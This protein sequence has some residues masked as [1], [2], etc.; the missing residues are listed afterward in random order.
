[1]NMNE[2]DQKERNTF[3]SSSFTVTDNSVT[4]RCVVVDDDDEEFIREGKSLSEMQPADIAGTLDEKDGCSN[5]GISK[6]SEICGSKEMVEPNVRPN[7]ETVCTSIPVEHLSI[8]TGVASA[9]PDDCQDSTSGWKKSLSSLGSRKK[10]QQLWRE[11]IDGFS[12]YQEWVAKNIRKRKKSYEDMPDVDIGLEEK[13][14]LPVDE[15][16][17]DEYDENTEEQYICRASLEMTHED[18]M[19]QVRRGVE[20]QGEE[21]AESDA[22]MQEIKKTWETEKLR[23]RRERELV[24][25]KE[26]VYEMMICYAC[27]RAF[28]DEIT[29]RNHINEQH[30]AQKNY[31]HKCRHCYRRFKLIH[32]LR[33]HEKLHDGTH[34]IKCDRCSAT[35]RTVKTLAIHKGRVHRINE[36]GKPISLDDCYECLKCHRYY[37]TVV[38]LNRHK[39]WCLNADTIK[40]KRRKTKL[41]QN[42]SSP[43]LSTRD[44]ESSP[45]GSECSSSSSRPKWDPVCPVCQ[46][47]FFNYPSMLRH[48]GRFHKGDVKLARVYKQT[49]SPNLPFA[50]RECFKRFASKASLSSHMKRHGSE[51]P[52]KCDQC[53]KSYIMGSEL[54]KH[55]RRVH[56]E[57]Q[58]NEII[59]SLPSTGL[60]DST[61]ADDLGCL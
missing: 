13:E 12:Q 16:E 17:D 41:E 29:L 6:D 11:E 60:S 3:D 42:I 49:S 1:M 52:F 25:S 31:D 7:S 47:T 51:R 20:A 59:M 28:D 4:V 19:A 46:K 37:P 35:F 34:L 48:M 8:E 61:A 50:C 15:E 57:A 2:V 27:G 32:H 55:I 40:E 23:I 26:K 14:D 53:T 22:L 21:T 18:F 44:C 30:L 33:R 9:S 43:S 39:Y 24:E 56:E 38:E 5:S 10:T 54:R 58:A 45:I 36:D